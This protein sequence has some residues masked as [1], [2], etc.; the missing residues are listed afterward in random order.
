MKTAMVWGASGGIGTALVEQ[1]VDED[2]RVIGLAR[3]PEAVTERATKVIEMDVADADSVRRAV[4]LVR[5]MVNTVDLWIYA[6]GD[7]AS[8]EVVD[9]VPAT[10]DRI[11]GANLTG[12]YRTAHF[13]LPL[14]AD[15]GH[16]IFLGAVSERMRLPGLGAYASAKAGLEA[17]AD[18]LRKEERRRRVTVVRPKAVDTSLWEKVPF[19]LPRGALSPDNLAARVLEAHRDGE[20][21]TLDI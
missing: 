17:L 6:A 1:L 16:M 15:D 12:A 11:V 18:V 8:E 5:E 14:L 2:W 10:W 7:I 19:S 13:S 3:D 20:S 4:E 21:G 9:M